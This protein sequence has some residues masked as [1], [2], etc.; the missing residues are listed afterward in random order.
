MSGHL[1]VMAGGTGGH[2]YPGLAIARAMVARGWRVSWMGTPN[3]M[4]QKLVDPKEFLLKSIAF[5]GLVGRGIGAKLRLP[6]LLWNATREAKQ[7]IAETNPT[8]VIGMGGYPTV[9]GGIAAWRSHVPLIIHQGDAVAGLANR[10]LS[11]FASSVLTGFNS[12]FAH[13]TAKRIVTGNPIRSEF[14]HCASV[15]ERFA[16]RTGPLQVLIMGGSR[17][18][19]ALNKTL[20]EAFARID[21]NKRPHILHQAGAGSAAAT[22]ERYKALG[23]EADVREFL[24]QSWTALSSAD[25]FIGR[26]GAS[27]VSELAALGVASV[28]VPYPH[29]ADQQQLHN[30]RV[31]EG[32]GAARIIEQND[33]APEAMATLITSFDRATLQRM[34]QAATQMAK[35]D[36]TARICDA[37]V[38]AA[39][40]NMKAVPA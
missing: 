20:P 16:N 30:A 22:A 17:G 8:A 37:I 36:A 15:A 29:H 14:T 7:H 21:A 40:A 39:S 19:E 23:V 26:S 38:A 12:T 11:R 1:I 4:E 33:L 35:P 18:A 25:L 32:V 13:L 2:I 10:L 31:L 3:G 6:A 24:D 5:E 28:L 27:T 9:P 34:A